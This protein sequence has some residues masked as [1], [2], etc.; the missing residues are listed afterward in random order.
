M[1]N[2]KEEHIFLMNCS[3]ILKSALG[4]GYVQPANYQYDAIATAKNILKKKVS[5]FDKM[6]NKSLHPVMHKD[7]RRLFLIRIC[8]IICIFNDFS[9][10]YP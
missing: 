3:R 2:I 1:I 9:P 10:P 6:I 4:P 5:K 7:Y 8:I